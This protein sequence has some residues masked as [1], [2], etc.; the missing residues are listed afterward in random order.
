MPP[1]WDEFCADSV[2][3]YHYWDGS[4]SQLGRSYIIE[5]QGETGRTDVGHSTTTTS[6][7]LTDPATGRAH[8]ATELDIWLWAARFTGDG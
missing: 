2:D 7:R 3:H 4:A 1:T 8:R 6:S 5:V